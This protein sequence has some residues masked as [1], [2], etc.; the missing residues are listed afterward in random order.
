MYTYRD[1]RQNLRTKHTEI[2]STLKTTQRRKNIIN[3]SGQI[4]K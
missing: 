1:A 2:H 3:N 4:N